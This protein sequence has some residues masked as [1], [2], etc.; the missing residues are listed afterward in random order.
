MNQK[1][2][3]KRVS[4]Q[5]T[6]LCHLNRTDGP[7]LVKPRSLPATDFEL[8]KRGREF[9]DRPRNSWK[10]RSRSQYCSQCHCLREMR[11]CGHPEFLIKRNRLS[12]V[13]RPK[14]PPNT[15]QFLMNDHVSRYRK[16]V[17]SKDSDPFLTEK[18][19]ILSYKL[20]DASDISY[21][22]A[23]VDIT[24]SRE[25]DRMPYT[26]D[27]IFGLKDFEEMYSGAC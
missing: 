18:E 13:Q 3:S 5:K 4:R 27:K 20:S 25:E 14:A 19:N 10:A 21:S 11:S 6:T 9:I 22:N 8:F 26:F 15:T 7:K 2:G 23:S 16:S 1:F 12:C 24:N 17:Y